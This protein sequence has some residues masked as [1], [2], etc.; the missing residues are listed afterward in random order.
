MN[1]RKQKKNMLQHCSL[2][3]PTPTIFSPTHPPKKKKVVDVLEGKFKD[4][5]DE[6]FLIDC[7]F[8]YEFEG[9][10]IRSAINVNTP[11]EL[12]KLLLQPAITDKRVLLIFH[13]EFSC[14]RGPRM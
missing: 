3:M 1:I 11:D 6:I 10:H 7:R 13:C 8:P 12:E 5:F 14:E 2:I 4:R 9:G